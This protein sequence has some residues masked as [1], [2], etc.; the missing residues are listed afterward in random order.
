MHNEAN[1]GYLQACLAA[2]RSMP[3]WPPDML[4]GLG[5]IFS[6]VREASFARFLANPVPIAPIQLDRESY[7]LLEVKLPDKQS[8]SGNVYPWKVVKAN[9][10]VEIELLGNRE[11]GLLR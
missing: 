7:V 8:A 3:I 9:L 1:A 11:T 5:L 10:G 2:L 6:E 4:C